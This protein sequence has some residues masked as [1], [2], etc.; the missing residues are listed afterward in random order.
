M[1]RSKARR[2]KERRG[3]TAEERHLT[4]QKEADLRIAKKWAEKAKA[5]F[6]GPQHRRTGPMVQLKVS[7][8]PVN[9]PP[10]ASAQP[11]PHAVAVR[12]PPPR[13][14]PKIGRVLDG[15]PGG[16]KTAVR[17]DQLTPAELA[18]YHAHLGDDDDVAL[19]N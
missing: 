12:K 2:L 17:V 1:C 8:R 4:C 18:A 7:A 11:R 5:A 3:E 14:P 9:V 19:L 13:P 16:P 10:T 6:P 15:L